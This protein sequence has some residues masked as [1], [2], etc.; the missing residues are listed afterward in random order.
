MTFKKEY[1]DV[2][3]GYKVKW[4]GAFALQAITLAIIERASQPDGWTMEDV[5]IA[6]RNAAESDYR[7]NR[8]RQ[9]VIKPEAIELYKQDYPI[10][11]ICKKLG[12]ARATCTK[13]FRDLPPNKGRR[14]YLA[15]A[16]KLLVQQ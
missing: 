12:V 5:L 11:V 10:R 1:N 14:E 7:L 8:Y 9:E 4:I 3:K 16:R 2:L 13:W 6:A 15:R